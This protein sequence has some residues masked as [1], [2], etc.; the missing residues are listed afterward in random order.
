[1]DDL[2]DVLKHWDLD[3]GLARLYVYHAPTPRERERWHAV[4]LLAGGWT[5]AEV[6]E[7]LECDKYTIGEWLANLRQAGPAGLTFEHAGKGV[8]GALQAVGAG[9]AAATTPG[10]SAPLEP[11]TGVSLAAVLERTRQLERTHQAPR[12]GVV[13]RATT[14]VLRLVFVGGVLG[15]RLP[16]LSLG[17]RNGPSAANG[18]PGRG[19]LQYR[20]H[21]DPL[22]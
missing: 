1:V 16:G 9:G 6:A 14:R 19:T 4:W 17:R 10:T 2:L 18:P 22:A 12:G 15:I 11:V 20:A 3:V 7:A 21:S 8:G 13:R 5:E